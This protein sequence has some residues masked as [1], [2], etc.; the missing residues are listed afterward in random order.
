MMNR[1]L[2]GVGIFISLAGGCASQPAGVPVQNKSVATRPMNAPKWEA[3]GAPV[4]N[5]VGPAGPPAPDMVAVKAA[6]YAASMKGAQVPNPGDRPA[7]PGEATALF[8]DPVKTTVK[9]NRQPRTE[10]MSPTGVAEGSPAGGSPAVGSPAGPILSNA[11]PAGDSHAPVPASAHLSPRTLQ[12]TTSDDEPKNLPES[13]DWTSASAG[14]D[15]LGQRL[16]KRARENPRDLSNQL[17]LQ[18]YGMLNDDQSPELAAVS[19]MPNEDRELVSALVDGL[20]NFRSTVRQD[21]NM[22]PAQK[23][24]PLLE[25]ADRL[26]SQADLTVSTVALCKKVDGFGKYEPFESTRFPAMHENWVIVYCEVENFL[27]K[28]NTRQQWET[29]LSEEVTLYTDTGL[30]VWSDHKQKLRDECRNRR[31]DFFAFDKIA[32]PASL[33]VGRYVLKVSIEDENREPSNWA[34]A[35]MPLT[36]T[37]Q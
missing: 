37:A 35:T 14:T 33:T 23:I 26:R 11:V 36:L 18:L 21:A 32:L 4:I 27:P 30:L 5:P 15:K 28:Q 25:M 19:I 7:V 9:K 31:H 8:E 10:S 2:L 6:E 24:K 17:D 3:N 13:A 1:R 22:L 29:N 34:E 12:K 16:M 20:S